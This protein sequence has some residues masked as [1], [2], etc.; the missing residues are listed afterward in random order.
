MYIKPV[1]MISDEIIGRFDCGNKTINKFLKYKSVNEY[2]KKISSTHIILDDDNILLGFYTIKI[3]HFNYTESNEYSD[4]YPYCLN[5]EYIAID[6][7]Q[8]NKGVGSNLLF[9]IIEEMKEISDKIGI[10]F[11]TVASVDNKLK[12]YE[13]F[14]F[15]K[16]IGHI[17]NL[18]YFDMLDI[19]RGDEDE[20]F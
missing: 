18:M 7:T 3:I 11:F 10:R 16:I 19:N 14:G 2:E 4:N 20:N 6:R 1:N 5:L 13:K 8:Q 9:Y 17:E 12:W 15:N